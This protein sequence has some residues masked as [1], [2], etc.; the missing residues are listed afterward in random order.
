MHELLDFQR[1]L[2][3][4]RGKSLLSEMRMVARQDGKRMG[5]VA[6][7][8]GNVSED[9]D[10]A[11]AAHQAQVDQCTSERAS[12]SHARRQSDTWT[13]PRTRMSS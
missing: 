8:R 4:N 7:S 5:L 9:Y 11:S 10:H 2:I 1:N 6:I 3:T 12:G 13:E